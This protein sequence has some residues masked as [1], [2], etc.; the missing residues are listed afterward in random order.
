VMATVGPAAI[1]GWS[2]RLARR[3]VAVVD[4]PVSGGVQRAGT[5]DL[6]VM[7]AS[8]AEVPPQV[9][10]V[11]AVL[12]ATAVEVG[13]RVGDGQR[14][15]LVNQ[16]LCGVHI[17]AA[18]EAL[19]LAESL[20]LDP[21][22]TWETVRHG[23]AAS[24]MLDDRGARMVGPQPAPVRSAVDIFVKDMGLVLD[25]ANLAGL[26]T[27][28]A[29]AAQQLYLRAKRAGLGGA[30]DSSLRAYLAGERVE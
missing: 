1:E 17:A 13:R 24:F 9:R 2:A 30:D 20:G 18:A 15:K 4:A 12:A 16:L 21:A 27:P 22:T 11:I 3:A 29:G 10:E 14:V 5:G 23:A 6:L 19:A 25:A 7:F 28:V 8:E 26:P